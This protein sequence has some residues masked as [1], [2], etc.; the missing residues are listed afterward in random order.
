M[1][2]EGA[3]LYA[4]RSVRSTCP[5]AVRDSMSIRC[6]LCA[7]PAL[8]ALAGAP[9]RGSG[10]SGAAMLG[11]AR[12]LK[13]YEPALEPILRQHNLLT[14]DSRMKERKHYGLRG[15]RRGTQRSL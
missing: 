14:R 6:L 3:A 1:P 15:A 13:L 2:T 12:A 9:S 7:L 4:L 8:L 5:P 11:V 10:Q